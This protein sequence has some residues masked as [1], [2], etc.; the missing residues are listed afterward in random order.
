MNTDV[1][2]L[3]ST[4]AELPDTWSSLLLGHI[5]RAGIKVLRMD[6]RAMAPESHPTAEALLVVDGHL[7][8][9]ADGI[10]VT[11]RAGEMYLI[12]AGV[13]H[14]VR[15]GSTGTLVIIDHTP[16]PTPHTRPRPEHDHHTPPAHPRHGATQAGA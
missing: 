2:D 9:V 6:G 4:A 1:V 3:P 13:V 12:E 5:G 8:L 14:A 15:P 11:V 16:H 10:D 7:Q